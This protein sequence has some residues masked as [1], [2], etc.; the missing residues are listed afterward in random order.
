MAQKVSSDVLD[1]G[2]N[3]IKTGV[4]VYVC[5]EEPT[6]RA[7][8]IA[9]SLIDAGTLAAGDYTIAAG[10]A[11]GRKITVA[12][13]TDVPITS[14]GDATHVVICTATTFLLCTT[15]NTQTLTSG[16][17][18]TIPAFVYESSQPTIV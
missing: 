11:N 7:A 5:T 8:A 13:Q 16:G 15:C 12:Q 1:G 6:D 2:L 4:E 14:T 9:T 17:T 3:A 18:V 10:T